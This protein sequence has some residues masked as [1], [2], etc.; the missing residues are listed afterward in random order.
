MRGWQPDGRSGASGRPCSGVMAP[1]LSLLAGCCALLAALAAAGSSDIY[2]SD[3]VSLD[4]AFDALEALEASSSS[5]GRRLSTSSKCRQALDTMLNNENWMYVNESYTRWCR[6]KAENEM[7]RCCQLADFAFGRGEGCAEG[8][9]CSTTCHHTNMVDLCGAHFGR[10]CNVDR[11]LFEGAPLRVS[12]T[13][14]VP[15][16]CDNGSDRENLIAWY[17]T[18]YAGRLNGWHGDWDDA[19]LECP[20]AAVGALLY[21]ILAGFIAAVVL[22]LLWILRVSPKQGGR[23][24]MTQEENQDGEDDGVDLRGAGLGGGDTIGSGGMGATR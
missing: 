15:E 12:E 4:S 23:V 11:K 6:I 21:T 22:P 7:A 9:G 3:T 14:C 8:T 20:N 2:G 18:L 5:P 24:L 17:S 16:G 10:A 13:F 1:A 19:K